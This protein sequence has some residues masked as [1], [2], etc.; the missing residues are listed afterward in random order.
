MEAARALQHDVQDF[1]GL[2]HDVSVMHEFPRISKDLL[3]RQVVE[4]TFSG[5]CL[6]R[7]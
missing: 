7:P 2:R 6:S 1:Q 3:H 4:Q 5:K